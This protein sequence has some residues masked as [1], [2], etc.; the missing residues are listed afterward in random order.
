VALFSG[1]E[2]LSLYIHVPF[3]AHKCGYCDFYSK[4]SV[5]GVESYISAFEKEISLYQSIYPHLI[6]RKVN[7]I[8]V[9]G[10]TPSILSVSQWKRVTDLIHT[11]FD[12]SDCFEWTI[13]VNPES[14]TTKKAEAWLESG[15]NRISM[16]VQSLDPVVL[17]E[18]ERIHT[19]ETVRTVLSNPILEKF[20]NISCDCIYGLP[21]QTVESLKATLDEL[22]SFPNITHISAY[23]LTIAEA[24][25]FALLPSNS[26]PEDELLA[27][28]EEVVLERLTGAGF[29][30]Y[31]VS[32]Y[33]KGSMCE[34][35]NAYWK[36][37]PYL[38]LGPSAHSFD[39]SH[40][41]SNVASLTAYSDSL[42]TGK[43]PFDSFEE[44]SLE[45][46]Q[47]EYL[48]LGLRTSAGISFDQFEEL[49][50]EP[51]ERGWR[52]EQIKILID[53]GILQKEKGHVFLT[54]SGLNI[55]DGVA[56]KLFSEN[57]M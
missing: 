49:F 9:G 38:G 1:D 40:R 36:M 48:F 18:A 23:E 37:R 28:Y 12:L 16:G 11:S 44:L 6:N 33:A 5:A 30:R 35:N 52:G 26:F 17:K 15:V 41:F 27:D 43:L 31:E 13:E 10:G 51:L 32:N 34:H 29:K 57:C 24:T 22:L 20:K 3:C 56:L 53:N 42:D 55:A 54:A 47:K 2:P 4:S 45:M 39:G 19:S 21:S 50:E 46:I 14:F 25:P 8:F 7:T